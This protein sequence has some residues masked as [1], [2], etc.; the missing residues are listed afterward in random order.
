MAE[1]AFVLIKTDYGVDD[2][3]LVGQLKKI[4]G[5]SEAYRIY[6]IYDILVKI[7]ARTIEQIREVIGRKLKNIRN[8]KSTITMVAIPSGQVKIA[9]R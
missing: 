5:I 9:G 7:E 6:G 2:D 3:I 1:R 4:E 8:I